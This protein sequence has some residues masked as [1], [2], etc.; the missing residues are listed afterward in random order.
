[1]DRIFAIILTGLLILLIFFIVLF[2]PGYFIVNGIHY[3]TG[4]GEH[5]GYVTAVER[6]GLIWKTGRAYIKSD[7]S[8]SQEDIYCVTDN[9]IYARLE[10]LSKDKT[11]VTIQYNDYFVKGLKECGDE[12][13]I[14]YGVK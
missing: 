8:S 7:T 14:I 4:K 6:N 9:N 2:I 11:K 13:A 3:E 12:Q 5:T 1:M 10:E